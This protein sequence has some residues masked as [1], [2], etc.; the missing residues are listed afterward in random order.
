M[1][2]L[3]AI[4]RGDVPADIVIK[5]AKIANVFTLEYELADVAIYG[6][7]IAGIGKNYD[8]HV[9]FDAKGKVL[10][11]GMIDGHVHIESSMMTPPAFAF[12]VALKGTSTIMADPHE[13]S[14]ALGMAGLE[15]MYTSSRG[16]PIDVFFGAPSCVPASEFETPYDELDMTAIKLM[17]EKKYT[18]HLGEMMNFPAVIAGDPEVWGKIIAAGDVPLTG[19]APGVAGKALNAYLASGV[20][21]DH[22]CIDPDEAREKLK[23]GMWIQIREGASFPNLKALLPVIR[24]NPLNAARCMIVSDDLTARYIHERG[25]MDEKMR[26][27]IKEG[28]NPFIALRMVTLSPAEY[29][30][31]WDRGAVAPGKIADFSLLDSDVMDEDFRVEYVWKNGRQIVRDENVFSA[32]EYEHLAPAIKIKVKKIPSAGQIKVRHESKLINVIGVSQGS[33]ITQTLQLEPKVK[34]GFV[35]QDHEN[36]VAKIVVLERHRD[37]G[38]FGVGF[39]KGLGVARGA[40]GSSVAHDAHNFVVAGADDESIITALKALADIRGGLVVVEKDKV[41]ASLALPV[42][43][44]MSYLNPEKIA[45][46]LT[47]LENAAEEL[48]VKIHHPFMTMSFLCLSV[49]PELRITDQGYVDIRKGRVNISAC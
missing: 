17:F 15:Y 26:I 32:S 9:V 25:H 19:H 23:R 42:G 45:A 8:G 47:K 48:G 46:E 20:S 24:E 12:A 21:S 44:L 18:Q 34:D 38:K 29:F 4:A 43:G 39:V 3:A 1:N 37:T 2:K 30:R 22:E 27:M 11:P 6:E 10:I 49:I 7:K 28:I 36:D 14:N 33:V 16:L 41:K 5:N 31:L 13:I 35:V 40:I